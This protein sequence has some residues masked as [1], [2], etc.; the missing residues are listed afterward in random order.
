MQPVMT[1]NTVTL[2]DGRQLGFA[3]VGDPGGMPL[4]YFHG[5]PGSRLEAL[6][7]E[8]AATDLGVCLIG[9][10]RPGYGLSDGKPGR[11]LGDW[12][13]DVCELADALDMD[14]FSVI[15]VSGGGP[16]AAACAWK[17]PQRLSRVAIVCGLGPLETA[18]AFRGMIALNRLGLGLCQRVSW[19]IRPLLAPFFMGLRLAPEH[20]ISHLTSKVRPV[21]RKTLRRSDVRRLLARTFREAFRHGMEGAVQDL[22]IYTKPWGFAL[23]DIEIKVLLWHGEKDVI[24]PPSMGRYQAARIPRCVAVFYRK[25]GHFSLVE[26]RGE[27]ILRALIGRTGKEEG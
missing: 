25:E 12:P 5:F 23:S 2:R 3:R 18:E 8:K 6:F 17:M 19:L 10:D 15:G 7:A 27:D 9:V 22:Q 4:F 16:Y 11:Q 13:C 26:H 20:A 21:D 1:D 14:R 24:V